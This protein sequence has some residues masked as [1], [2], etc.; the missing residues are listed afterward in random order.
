MIAK[1]LALFA[2][3]GG[4]DTELGGPWSKYRDDPFVKYLPNGDVYSID[5]KRI[6]VFR[7]RKRVWLA[8]NHTKNPVVRYKSLIQ[9]YLF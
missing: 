9:N 7:E 2:A 5:R 8:G 3:V 4:G 1:W 6:S